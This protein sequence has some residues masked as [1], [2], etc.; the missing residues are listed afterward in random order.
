M[1][2]EEIISAMLQNDIVPILGI[3]WGSTNKLV[4]DFVQEY[5]A[6]LGEK[7][8]FDYTK[9]LYWFNVG[10]ID[11]RYRTNVI[12]RDENTNKRTLYQIIMVLDLQEWRSALPSGWLADYNDELYV[13]EIICLEETMNFK[14]I[15][16]MT[17]DE[18]LEKWDK[19]YHSDIAAGSSKVK[20]NVKIIVEDIMK[21]HNDAIKVVTGLIKA[22]AASDCPECRCYVSRIIDSYDEPKWL[23][24]WNIAN[25]GA[26]PVLIGD[27]MV[28]RMTQA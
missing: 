17:L 24:L 11:D 5:L 27:K 10:T 2:D 26:F 28:C 4:Q 16:K 8:G 20:S 25:T 3:P 14:N 12:Y 19:D 7:F 23:Y 15:P 18:A 6:R 1:S 22:I 21:N 13:F 9:H